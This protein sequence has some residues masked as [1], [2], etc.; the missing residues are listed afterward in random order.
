MNFYSGGKR[1]QCFAGLT[2]R[3][4]NGVKKTKKLKAGEKL[5]GKNK[6]ATSMPLSDY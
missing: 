6:K 3:E 4:K 2:V 5:G 1:L